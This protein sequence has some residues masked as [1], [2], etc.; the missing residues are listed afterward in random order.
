MSDIGEKLK[1]AGYDTFEARFAVL[2]TEAL[3]HHPNSVV[4]AWRYMGEKF[5]YE[6]LRARMKDMKGSAADKD[7]S[8]LAPSTETSIPASGSPKPDKPRPVP[9]NPDPKKLEKVTEKA[10]EILFGYK[11]A[12][13]R[14]IAKVGAHEVKR[15][16]RD[17][18]LLDEI[19][20]RLPVLT[21][22]MC[23]MD[24]GELITAEQFDEARKAAGV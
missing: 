8:P 14:D 20:K 23:F 10:K 7:T 18:R 16:V 22:N 13:G 19:D 2:A 6:Y 15:F 1:E 11:I 12:D 5:G 24:L 9:W 3:R 4:S 21:D 17:G